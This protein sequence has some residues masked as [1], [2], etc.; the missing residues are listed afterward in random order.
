MIYLLIKWIKEVRF[1]LRPTD[2]PAIITVYEHLTLIPQP[3][4]I[5]IQ[6]TRNISLA[7]SRQSNCTYSNFLG[8]IAPLH[9]IIINLV[10]VILGLKIIL[11]KI[12][13]SGLQ[14]KS[15]RTNNHLALNFLNRRQKKY[16]NSFN[17]KLWL[18]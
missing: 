4:E 14:A 13:G 15:N 3:I 10:N 16:C 12:C 7:P 11:Y 6:F 17:T 2:F 1:T 8:S 9:F 5:S 18:I